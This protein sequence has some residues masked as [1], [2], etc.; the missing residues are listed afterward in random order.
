MLL[1]TQTGRFR[2]QHVTAGDIEAAGF[3]A[4]LRLALLMGPRVRR[5]CGAPGVAE[6]GRVKARRAGSAMGGWGKGDVLGEG[7][8]AMSECQTFRSWSKKYFEK[9]A[10]RGALAAGEG[11]LADHLDAGLDLVGW[12]LRDGGAAAGGAE[13]GV[14]DAVRLAGAVAPGA[15]QAVELLAEGG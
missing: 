1:A 8:D 9:L 4:T 5:W 2:V 3:A 12:G 11:P 7:W 13:L 14:D 6:G 15:D 10:Q